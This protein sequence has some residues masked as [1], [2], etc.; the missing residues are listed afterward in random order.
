M[1][2]WGDRDWV[3]TVSVLMAIIISLFTYK[4]WGKTGNLIDVISIGSGLSSF[5]LAIS[6]IVISLRESNRSNETLRSITNDLRQSERLINNLAKDNV[7]THSDLSRVKDQFKNNDYIKLDSKEE[8]FVKGK[9]EETK[10]EDVKDKQTLP[11][12]GKVKHKKLHKPQLN[13]IV[14]KGEVFF[15]DLGSEEGSELVGMRPVVIVQNDI[16]N[17]FSPTA[18]VAPVTGQIQVAKLPT[19]VEL[20]SDE[21]G[22]DRDSVIL[23]EYI[24]TIDKLKLKEKITELDRNKISEVNKALEFQLDLNGIY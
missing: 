15:A 5:T 7:K 2:N 12:T 22:F 20:N 19:Q 1:K 14:R 8:Q 24:Q 4:L 16:G 23:L 17:R 11:K 21:Y 3:W 6:A 9:K 18:T 13:K 10:Q